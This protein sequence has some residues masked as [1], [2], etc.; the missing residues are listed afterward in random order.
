MLVAAGLYNLLA[1]TLAILFPTAL[2]RWAALEPPNYPELMQGIGL[3][4]AT[5]GIGYLLAARDPLRH[6]AVIVVGLIGKVLGVLAVLHVLYHG[7]SQGPLPPGAGL[8]LLALDLLWLPVL[9]ALVWQLYRVATAP[10]DEAFTEIGDPLTK[11]ASQ[12]GHTLAE[13]SSERPVLVTFLRHAGCPF[14]REALASIA[15]ARSELEKRGIGIAL[16]HMADDA[17]I[18]PLVSRYGL[19]DVDR[20]SDPER[21]L[22]RA[23][24]L[25][26]GSLTQVLGPKVWWRG[27]MVALLGGHG[28]GPVVGDVLQMPGVFILHRGRIVA[29]FQH[30]SSADR[31]DLAALL[32][33]CDSACSIS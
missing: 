15:Q 31:P 26:R 17:T 21:R 8:L 6:V 30:R 2:F 7:T 4:V 29:S 16:V 10:R 12:Q 1:G 28:F 23:C 27:L 18:L 3:L 33:D 5:F 11:L 14:C 22:Y 20:F 32:K 9:L 19:A 24:G 13:L 25:S